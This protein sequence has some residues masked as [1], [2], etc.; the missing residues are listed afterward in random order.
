MSFQAEE[1]AKK[2]NKRVFAGKAC[3]QVKDSWKE[4]TRL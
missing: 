1:V 4:R 2:G 3:L